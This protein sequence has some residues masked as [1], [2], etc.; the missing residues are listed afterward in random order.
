MPEP[1]E[2]AVSA[3]DMLIGVSFAVRMSGPLLEAASEELVAETKAMLQSVVHQLMAQHP[4]AILQGDVGVS[5]QL[6]RD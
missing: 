2:S 6:M 5:I 1:T 3:D 4:H